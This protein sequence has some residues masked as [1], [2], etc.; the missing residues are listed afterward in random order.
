MPSPQ[1]GMICRPGWSSSVFIAAAW[2]SMAVPF[3]GKI[4]LLRAAAAGER[5]LNAENRAA[6]I[7]G[8]GLLKRRRQPR[9]PARARPL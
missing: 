9:P 1:P 7:D 8:L 4:R 3:D 2:G 5:D 6:D